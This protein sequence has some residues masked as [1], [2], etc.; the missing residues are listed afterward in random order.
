MWNVRFISELSALEV[1]TLLFSFV[2][3]VPSGPGP[4]HSGGF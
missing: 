3:T 4:P 1:N 2:A